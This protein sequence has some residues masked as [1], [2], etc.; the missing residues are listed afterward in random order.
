MSHSAT[1]S[2]ATISAAPAYQPPSP[3]LDAWDPLAP[4]D[5]DVDMFAAAQKR[6]IR[7][8][9]K[10]YTGYYDLFSEMIQNAL[11][12][13]EKRSAENVQGYQ[14]EIAINIDIQS[15]SVT[16]T[17]N[18]CSMNLQQFKRF[19][20]PNFSFKDGP[21]TRGSKGVGATYLA[22]GFNYL[23]LATKPTT[24]TTYSGVL[25]DGRTW[26]DDGKGIIPRPTVEP[27]SDTS[28]LD[29]FDRGTSITLKLVGDNIRPKSLQ[30]F[31]AKDA[32]QWICLL[33]AHT[34]LGGLYL[35]SETPPKIKIT[36]KVVADKG[37]ET[38]GKMEAPRYLYPHEVLGKTA[39]LREFLK[40]QANRAAKN[41]DLA[42]IPPKFTN[43]NGMWGEWTGTEI[44]S[45]A[46]PLN[47][48]WSA[49]EKEL[50]QEL[51]PRIYV[52][53]CYSTDLWDDY[54][55]NVL[56]L[57]KGTRICA[58]GSSRQQSICRKE[59]R[60]LFRSPIT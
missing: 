35:C 26:L 6:E 22:F 44:L 34:P 8:I 54:N 4:S 55:D 9:L 49:G 21:A 28:P 51:D 38:I 27:Q 5:D 37:E 52:F 50:M 60:S 15:N 58:A 29:H 39:D 42:K 17:D 16:V 36:V 25:K 10:S 24:G 48:A 7:N 19:L 32:Q 41:Q 45:G 53:M 2:K 13:V 46:T 57:R 43:L 11:D 47:P 33:R 12:A 3:V 14:P 23:R 40:D 56:K 59:I 31:I 1:E 30:Y 20:K 18:G